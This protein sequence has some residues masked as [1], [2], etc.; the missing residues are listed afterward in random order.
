MNPKLIDSEYPS[1]SRGKWRSTEY[2]KS[3]FKPKRA[4]YSPDRHA[5]ILKTPDYY[6]DSAYELQNKLIKL[7]TNL[8]LTEKSS[9]HRRPA[10]S[11]CFIQISTFGNQNLSA[12]IA[13]SWVFLSHMEHEPKLF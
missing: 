9:R 11:I 4:I 6:L 2:D 5:L 13:C 1:I 12:F 8:A 7:F 10:P 3:S